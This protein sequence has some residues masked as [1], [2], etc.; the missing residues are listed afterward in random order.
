[1]DLN[2]RQWQALEFL[3]R[4]GRITN[5]EVL[6]IAPGVTA[7]TIRRDLADLVGRGLLLKI[8]DRR[9]TYYIL[10]QIESTNANAG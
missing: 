5:R 7:E 3:T 10:K 4:N 6:E 8:G 9:G 2:P 1:M